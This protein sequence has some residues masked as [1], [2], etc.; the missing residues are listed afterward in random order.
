MSNEL[1]LRIWRKE[2]IG[3]FLYVS[4]FAHPTSK[5]LQQSLGLC[6][7][8]RGA[9]RVSHCGVNY[10]VGEGQLLV[11]QSGDVLSCEDY[12]GKAKYRLF[13][14]D[15]KAMET[16]VEEIRER[17]SGGRIFQIFGMGWRPA[18]NTSKTDRSAIGN[19]WREELLA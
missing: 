14:S 11:A 6:F 7:V 5:I 1:K 18:A 2:G 13:Q 16:I 8:E 19:V 15:P 9:Y 10:S 3:E 17:P 4:N 12:D